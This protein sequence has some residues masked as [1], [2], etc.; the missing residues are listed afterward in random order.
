M[1]EKQVTISSSMS[2]KVIEYLE[3]YKDDNYKFT[4]LMN[5]ST[6]N[7]V[8]KVETTESDNDKIIRKIK[9]AIKISPFGSIIYFAVS[10]Q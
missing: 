1:I 5:T 10:I 9:D 4:Y 8:F 3:G 6:L 7:A 2:S